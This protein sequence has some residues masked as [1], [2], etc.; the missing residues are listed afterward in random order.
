[1]YI[2]KINKNKNKVAAFMLIADD[3]ERDYSNTI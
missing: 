2:Y 3:E 1:M